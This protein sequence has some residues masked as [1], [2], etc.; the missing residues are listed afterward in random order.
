M[1]LGAA[2]DRLPVVNGQLPI[3]GRRMSQRKHGVPESSSSLILHP[4]N[5]TIIMNRIV[6]G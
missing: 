4:C 5:I 2:G 6:T 1:L 3:V